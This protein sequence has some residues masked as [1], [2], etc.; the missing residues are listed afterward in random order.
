MHV[1]SNDFSALIGRELFDEY[2]L[3]ILQKEVKTMDRNIFH[4]DGRGVANH[5][6]SILTVPEIDF[7]IPSFWF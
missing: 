2:C 1:P 6:D 3:P 7:S 4:L 5:I